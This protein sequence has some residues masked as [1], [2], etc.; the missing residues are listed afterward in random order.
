MPLFDY[1]C[2]ECG[3]QSELL[4]GTTAR[5][6][7]P[8]CGSE[9]MAKLLPIVASPSRGAT[10]NRGGAPPQGSCGAGCGCH[11]RG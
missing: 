9:Q 3:E 7:C 4:V 1:R 5:P 11:P 8:K 10:A 2:K 6:Q